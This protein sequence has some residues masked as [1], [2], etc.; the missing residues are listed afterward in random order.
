M[1]YPF[2]TNNQFYFTQFSL[3]LVHSLII[4]NILFPAIQFVQIVLIL[5]INLV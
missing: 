5:P 4:K 2:Y 3:A 1:P